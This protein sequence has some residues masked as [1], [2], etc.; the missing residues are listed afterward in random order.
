MVCNNSICNHR[1]PFSGSSQIRL[2]D[3]SDSRGGRLEIYF[4]GTWGTVCDDSWDA[5]D[6]EVACQE[7]GFV[8]VEDHKASYPTGEEQIWL[9]D[10]HCEGGE[11]SI[12]YCSHNGWGEHNCAHAE[13]VGIVCRRGG[14][15]EC[16]LLRT[17]HFLFKIYCMQCTSLPLVH[18][19]QGARHNA[20]GGFGG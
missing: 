4:E 18:S 15:G 7:L 1:I 3:G 11:S 8:G 5:V 20:G 6:A 17:I 13:D 10:V 19:Y 14:T 16:P 2:V 9:D 12:R